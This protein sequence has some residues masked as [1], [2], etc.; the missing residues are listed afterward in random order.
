VKPLVAHIATTRAELT[1]QRDLLSRE[2]ALLASVPSLPRVRQQVNRILTNSRPRLLVG[3]SVAATA[4]LATLVDGLATA[5]G[6]RVTSL[7]GQSPAANGALTAVQVVLRGE[8]RWSQLL[9]F[10]R[11]LES[12]GTLID[13]ASLR[14][15]R[16]SLG[17]PGEGNLV[18]FGATIRGLGMVKR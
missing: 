3:D 9:G 8:A 11:T 16:S 5:H 17:A 4:A 15:E 2:Q 7:E 1:Q 6:V 14:M 13:V 10:I 12:S 18:S